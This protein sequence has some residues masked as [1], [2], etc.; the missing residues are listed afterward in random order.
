MVCMSAEKDLV[1]TLKSG[2]NLIITI[3]GNLSK[4]VGPVNVC[5]QDPMHR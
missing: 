2:G 1:I 4:H 3:I 5:M